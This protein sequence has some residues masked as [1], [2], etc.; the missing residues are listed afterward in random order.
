MESLVSPDRVTVRADKLAL[1][2]LR[3]DLGASMIPQI[4]ADLAELFELR[5]VI[6]VHHVKRVD[7]PAIGAR[8]TFT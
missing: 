3:E 1:A 4:A 5:Q 7:I 8:N 6:P 2:D